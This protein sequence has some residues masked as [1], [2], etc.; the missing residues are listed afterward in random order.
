MYHS[1]SC[2]CMGSIPAQSYPRRQADIRKDCRIVSKEILRYMTLPVSQALHSVEQTTRNIAELTRQRDRTCVQDFQLRRRKSDEK[3]THSGLLVRE[4]ARWASL[5][6]R[7][8]L[9]P[10]KEG[11]SL[12]AGRAGRAA[13]SSN[14]VRICSQ[15]RE[16]DPPYPAQTPWVAGSC[17][18]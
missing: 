6:R 16:H 18:D 13:K 8:P 10:C 17:I 9:R 5:Q 4:A 11:C 14:H 12:P 2:Q 3:G 1:K 7:P 15:H